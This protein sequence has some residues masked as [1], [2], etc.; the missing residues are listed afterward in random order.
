MMQLRP[1]I[2][3]MDY[4]RKW[5]KDSDMHGSADDT[6]YVPRNPAPLR[7]IGFS[8][9]R[10]G[11]TL[12]EL[13]VVIAI[14][15]VLIALL[16]PAVQAAR[17]AARRAQCANQLKQIALACHIYESTF[18]QFP[19]GVSSHVKSSATENCNVGGSGWASA[20]WTVAILPQ[21]EE[22]NRYDRFDMSRP[23]FSH[24]PSTGNVGPPNEFEQLKPLEKFKCPTNASFL[25]EDPANS[26]YGVM[27]GG[28]KPNSE[29][30]ACN[31]TGTQRVYFYNGIF[32][33]NSNIRIAQ[34]TDG[35]SNTYMIG[36]TKYHQLKVSWPLWYESWASSM[37]VGINDPGSG[38][39]YC[40][41]AATLVG[42]NALDCDP[43]LT[44]CHQHV[45]RGFGSYH[46]GGCHFAM[47]D[48]S[49]DYVS[50]DI[51]LFV[52][53]SRGSRN[54]GHVLSD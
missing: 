10:Y 49:V 42:I 17:E 31:A 25:A 7:R 41:I 33:N 19:P 40:N 22:Q 14:I 27:G 5:S 52:Y 26:Y 12:V 6:H 34:I 30:Q 48:A 2:G 24:Y 21:L 47:A 46:P 54:D 11:F 50:E 28:A 4:T 20:P 53:Q 1:R 37:F 9:S 38:T 32:Y 29:Y 23:F 45:T 36:E 39:L 13:L 16:L 8:L 51:D 18:K 44:N 35:T 3:G 15:G 43:E